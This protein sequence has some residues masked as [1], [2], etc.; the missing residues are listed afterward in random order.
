VLFA[1]I[2]GRHIE[3]LGKLRGSIRVSGK[4]YPCL[5]GNGPAALLIDNGDVQLQLIP[6]QCRRSYGRCGRCLDCEL[7][8]GTEDVKST[9]L[10]LDL[11][12]QGRELDSEV[13]YPRACTLILA[14]T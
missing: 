13:M 6:I 5:G 4:G 14:H 3:Y 7:R 11:L 10:N 2:Q 1:E 9:A 12:I 8:L